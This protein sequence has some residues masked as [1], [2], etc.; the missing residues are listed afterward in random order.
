M[1]I[2]THKYIYVCFHIIQTNYLPRDALLLATSLQHGSFLSNSQLRAQQHETS[3][4][5]ATENRE[6][7]NMFVFGKLKW[8][9]VY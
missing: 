5:M 7:D 2:H 6:E 4:L 9:V 8:F 1:Y 3:L